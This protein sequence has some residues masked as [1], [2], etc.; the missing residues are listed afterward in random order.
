MLVYKPPPGEG[1]LQNL[2]GAQTIYHSK[3]LC[4]KSPPREG[5]LSRTGHIGGTYKPD[6]TV[7]IKAPGQSEDLAQRSS[8]QAVEVV[9]RA[10]RGSDVIAARRLPSGDTILTF[11]RKSEEYTKDTAWVQATFGPSAQV[12]PREFTV[13]AKGLLAQRLQAIHD[14]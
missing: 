11:E 7:V 12:K 14:P 10:I 6:Y 8:T 9:N 1:S 4:Y 13:I 5:H 3:S 2:Y